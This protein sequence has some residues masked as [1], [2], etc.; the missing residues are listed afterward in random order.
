MS[1]EPDSPP[2]WWCLDHQR[3]EGRE[4]CANRVRLGPFD[5]FAEAA[6]AL[7]RARARTEAW[8]Q[9]SGWSDEAKD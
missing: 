1:S 9:D 2:Y 4:G 8:D 5:D 6:T 3:V 7:E